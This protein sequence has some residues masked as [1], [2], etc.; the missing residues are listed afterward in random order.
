MVG[1]YHFYHILAAGKK[2]RAIRP[3]FQ[4]P[5]SDRG[6]SSSILFGRGRE[7]AARGS[8]NIFV[9]FLTPRFEKER[10][11]SGGGGRPVSYRYA[12]GRYFR[13]Y[14]RPFP[15]NSPLSTGQVGGIPFNLPLLLFVRGRGDDRWRNREARKRRRRKGM[16][17]GRRRHCSSIT[18]DPSSSYACRFIPR[19]G[20]KPSSVVSTCKLFKLDSSENEHTRT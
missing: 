16:Q 7:V 18:E 8:L 4:L 13:K 2:Q 11:V 19:G 1:F 12:G 10:T 6:I 17:R 15:F 14:P 20:Q 9:G 3:N 5:R